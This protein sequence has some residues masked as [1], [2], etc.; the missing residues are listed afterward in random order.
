M[1]TVLPVVVEIVTATTIL[2]I[3]VMA[4]ISAT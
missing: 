2:A 4:S 1:S 3:H